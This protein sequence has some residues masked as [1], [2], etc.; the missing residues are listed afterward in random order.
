M[1]PSS[2]GW[3]QGL[4]LRP[5]VLML[6]DVRDVHVPLRKKK[7][8]DCLLVYAVETPQDLKIKIPPQLNHVGVG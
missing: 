6:V 5:G 3:L 8:L 2:G 4:D 1:S 7:A